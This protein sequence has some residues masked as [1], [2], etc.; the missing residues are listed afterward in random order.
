[1][2]RF[3][4]AVRAAVNNKNWHGALALGVTIP[5]VCGRMEFPTIGSEAR[6]KAWWDKYILPKYNKMLYGTDAYA[7]RCAYLHEGTDDVISQRASRALSNFVF[8]VPPSTGRVHCNKSNS[9]LQLQVDIFCLDL[10]DGVSKWLEDVQNNSE[11]LAR[12][13]TLLSVKDLRDGISF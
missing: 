8:V 10:S 11:I 9:T 6:Y 5:D 2:K 3:A 12:M 4:D 13:K 7:L 1:M